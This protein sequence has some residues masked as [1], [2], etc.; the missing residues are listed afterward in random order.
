MIQNHKYKP[1]D[2]V[3]FRAWSDITM[4]HYDYHLLLIERCYGGGICEC[5]YAARPLVPIGQL[6]PEHMNNSSI[7]VYEYDLS[8]D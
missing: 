1:G 6:K 7:V 3:R 8:N 2:V 4:I 5:T